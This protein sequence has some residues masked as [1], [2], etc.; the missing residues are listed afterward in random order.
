M[1][2]N[3]LVAHSKSKEHLLVKLKSKEEDFV[4][5]DTS[6]SVTLVFLVPLYQNVLGSPS[7]IPCRNKFILYSCDVLQILIGS[8]PMMGSCYNVYLTVYKWENP[9]LGLNPMMGYC[10]NVYF[11]VY[12]CQNSMLGRNPMM[13]S[14]YNVYFT[15]YN[16]QNQE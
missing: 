3:R 4:N 6:Q 2:I 14:C 16:Y 13:G 10:Y 7:S 12:N 1:N 11:N 8:N 9:M 5:S 15:L